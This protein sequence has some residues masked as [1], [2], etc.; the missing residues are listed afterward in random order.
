[1]TVDE[2]PPSSGGSGSSGASGGG[3]HR[4]TPRGPQHSPGPASSVAKVLSSERGVGGGLGPP[5]SSPP[6]PSVDRV[7][8]GQMSSASGGS[9]APAQ[10]SPLSKK[11]QQHPTFEQWM[12]TNRDKA[13]V[14]VDQVREITGADTA[15]IHRAFNATRNSQDGEFSV[16]NALDWI[17]SGNDDR[18]NT[19]SVTS[20]TE[21]GL[22]TDS[23]PMTLGSSGHQQPP[24]PAQRPNSPNF[25][26]QTFVDLTEAG[27]SPGGI[28]QGSDFK[29]PDAL[30]TTAATGTGPD[31]DLEKAIA[32]S[33]Q[34]HNK[35]SST[36][37]GH[38]SGIKGVNQEDE[39]V[40]R[41]LEASLLE[42]Q[43]RNGL[44]FGLNG[45]GEAW[46]DPLNPHDRKRNAMWPVGLKNVGQTCWFS[47]VIQ[48]L[49]YLPAFRSYV[50]EYE[51]PANYRKEDPTTTTIAD[52]QRKIVEFMLELRRLFALMVGTRRKYVD[53]S[54][55]VDI[56]RGSI[57]QDQVSTGSKTDATSSTAILAS[58]DSG[59]ETGV[60]P[61]PVPPLPPI[62]P[63]T[64]N[65]LDVGN[66]QD[67]S[68]FTHIVLEW[69]EEAFKP[70]Q[71]D[72]TQMEVEEKENC[73][74]KTD[75][76]E[77]EIVEGDEDEED[78]SERDELNFNTPKDNEPSAANAKVR[79]KAARGR[80]NRMSKL[81][82][83]QV[84]IEGFVRGKE[85]SR[86]EAFGQWPLQVNSYTDIHESLE[87]S[88]AHE[89]LSDSSSS[90]S[91]AAAEK[92]TVGNDSGSQAAQLPA[93][94]QERWFTRLPP[95]LFLELSRFHY[96]TE[97]KVAEKIHSRLDFPESIYMDRYMRS[98]KSVTRAKREEVRALKERQTQL[99]NKLSQFTNYSG[100]CQQD[101]DSV[102]TAGKL[103]LPE[104]LQL[105]MDFVTSGSRGITAS[106]LPA[107]LSGAKVDVNMS[108]PSAG[109]GGAS[110]QQQ[111]MESSPCQSPGADQS[112]TGFVLP[113]AADGDDV[114]MDVEMSE[115][116]AAAASPPK[117]LPSNPAPDVSCQPT[118]E[119][120][121]TQT[122]A[123]GLVGCESALLPSSPKSMSDNSVSNVA[124]ILLN[125][126]P[127]PRHISEPE[128]G[129]IQTCLARWKEE[130]REDIAAL[131]AA[132]TEVESKIS[133]M[134]T[135]PELQCLK[136]CLH[137]VMV[138]EGGVESGHY[139]AYVR[140]HK[141]KVWLKFND[142]TVNEASW[143]ELVKESFGGHSNTSAYSLV[144]IDAAKPDLLCLDI[145]GN[146]AVG[147]TREDLLEEMGLENIT[148]YLPEEL[149]EFILADN[150]AFEDEVEEW[151]KA[152]E[153]KKK[154]EALSKSVKAADTTATSSGGDPNN[155]IQVL[156]EFTHVH[157]HTRLSVEK[158]YE[159]I[160]SVID[161][162]FNSGQRQLAQQE[163]KLPLELVERSLETC[164]DR[165]VRKYL[166]MVEKYD[167][168]HQKTA[169]QPQQ[170]RLSHGERI[171]P[172]HGDVR[173]DSF[174]AYL[175]KNCSETSV[176]NPSAASV[177]KQ[178]A[179]KLYRLALL[180]QLTLP[181]L[182]ANEGPEVLALKKLAERRLN[183]HR[184][185]LPD[186]AEFVRHWHQAYHYFRRCVHYFVEGVESFMV[187]KFRESLDQLSQAYRFN[188][189]LLEY[190]KQHGVK[191]PLL[192]NAPNVGFSSS[193]LCRFLCLA[194][195]EVN[196]DLI[197]QF[198][199]V[200]SVY[201]DGRRVTSGQDIC[202][203]VKQLVVPVL[204]MLQARSNC[205]D[206]SKEEEGVLESV[207]DSW[208]SLL[209]N[210][211]SADQANNSASI[212][213]ILGVVLELPAESASLMTSCKLSEREKRE[214]VDANADMKLS[215]RYRS[216]VRK[217]NNSLI[218]D[219]FNKENVP[220]LQHEE[221][222]AGG[223]NKQVK[224]N[225]PS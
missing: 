12:V 159:T 120:V 198:N 100:S 121:N 18:A 178:Q 129:V 54:R 225:V 122:A 214:I 89:L 117:L 36:G 176:T 208:C 222:P 72:N 125:K 44:K 46:A 93:A 200:Q 42:S 211:S 154:A 51:P 203:L 96:N 108:S 82:Y 163:Q 35:L 85:F 153:E 132:V 148:S 131:E 116:E 52:R 133:G 25:G 174:I 111:P 16:E 130:V 150:K 74:E 63:P 39:D 220:A 188:V 64:V 181:N 86:R 67:V 168:L 219:P 81:F 84:L 53:P 149:V 182:E 170:L 94:G 137:A 61:P 21:A 139:W 28:S 180:E 66:Q 127:C 103:S 183:E 4:G 101:A 7:S 143:E 43:T 2:T 95:V 204:G 32:L 104:V 195:N 92:T 113:G 162:C 91:T 22:G 83:G 5:P 152:Q 38:S 172:S 205:G 56:L 199:R 47:A 171:T 123:A 75:E 9:P 97:K 213:D 184:D 20:K 215:E 27:S 194:V 177:N 146:A 169:A 158:T 166:H 189:L 60:P 206:G 119:V 65:I 134:Y 202:N 62:A 124:E 179:S 128:L 165:G 11:R 142:N 70:N 48:S 223:A 49:F 105:T 112:K 221:P 10:P 55:A 107:H 69:V 218:H 30:Q 110:N 90:N 98:N 192:Y 19:R 126:A 197:K 23:Q 40:S 78:I 102:S 151:D 173:L 196:R 79:K 15:R 135:Q 161:S 186:D 114:D 31:D 164:L 207:R 76:D 34:E 6:R 193:L 201:S 109:S 14:L 71:N 73:E 144:Y 17:F 8:G 13:K 145:K 224:F 138:H 26:N 136:Y 190:P 141:R 212:T 191:Y 50:F 106:T 155:D 59:G 41:A 157:T 140:D 187:G 156:Q 210:E 3:D 115:A 216:T 57:G 33:L 185:K 175:I 24:T 209:S 29:K 1:M 118:E 80:G 160:H 167:E 87:G 217:Y 68:E 147:E 88:T 77:E 58:G 37:A 99:K 45:R